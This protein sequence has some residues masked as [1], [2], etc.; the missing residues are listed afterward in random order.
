MRS[1]FISLAAITLAGTLTACGGGAEQSNQ[2]TP[3]TTAT[4]PTAAASTDKNAYPVLLNAD[5]GADSAVSADQG[6]Q[7]FTG[8]GWETNTSFDLVGDPRAVKGG[9]LKEYVL[10]FPGTLR[11]EGPES[12]SA[13][14]YMIGPMVYESLLTIHPTTLDY[15]PV[16]ATHWQVS[17]DKSTYRFRINPNARW[18]DGQPVIADDVVASWTFRMDK[19]L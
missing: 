1:A 11:T 18:A 9:L 14:N 13:L 7:G 4:Q 16:L 3:S 17:A 5:E 6:G 15:M 8:E 19:G 10:D 12:N 2:Q